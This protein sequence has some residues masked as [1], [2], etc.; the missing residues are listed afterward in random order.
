MKKKYILSIIIITLLVAGFLIISIINARVADEIKSEM[1]DVFGDLEMMIDEVDIKYSIDEVKVNIL[2]STVQF[3]DFRLNIGDTYD[4]LSI[5]FKQFEL[6]TDFES[7]IES[8]NELDNMLYI[9]ERNNDMSDRQLVKIFENLY[10]INKDI[11]KNYFHKIEGLRVSFSD[12]FSFKI[13]SF[14]LESSIQNKLDYDEYISLEENYSNFFDEYEF[15]E[16]N[17]SRFVNMMYDVLDLLPEG[18]QKID[19]S[20]FSLRIPDLTYSNVIFGG[21]AIEFDKYTFNY[22]KD[23]NSTRINS[24]AYTNFAGDYDLKLLVDEKIEEI[25][26]F[27]SINTSGNRLF[28]NAFREIQESL[29]FFNDGDKRNTFEFEFNGSYEEFYSIF[30]FSY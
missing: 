26:I 23:N 18:D 28:T 25:D 30:D 27:G 10:E 4:E 29:E 19:I 9:I 11:S 21:K 20:E 16:L 13:D 1:D 15:Y 7:L 3:E 2:T 5:K 6:S 17:E 12:Y 24:K 22:D 8:F 14:V